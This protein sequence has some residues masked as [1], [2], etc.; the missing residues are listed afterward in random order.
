MA[1]HPPAEEPVEEPGSP[2]AVPTLPRRTPAPHRL[3]D[4]DD[5]AEDDQVHQPDQE[6][7]AGWTAASS[8]TSSPAIPSA[9]F[10]LSSNPSASR[11]RA[12]IQ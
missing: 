5:A 4:F 9:C 2:A 10:S 7:E 12:L 11:I 8:G 1:L 3:E 6:Q